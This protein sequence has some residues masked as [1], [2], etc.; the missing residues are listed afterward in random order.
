VTSRS[1]QEILLLHGPNLN[2]LGARDEVHYGQVT[3]AELVERV[4]GW[5]EEA[6]LGVRAVQ[7]NHEGELIDA[8]QD[9]AAWA[10]GAIVNA[11]ALTHT[12]YALHDALLDFGRPA[13]E[14]HLSRISEREPWRRVSV[15]RPACGA[16][17]EGEG[18]EGYR[19][20][21]SWLA[22]EI[23]ERDG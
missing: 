7:S 10:R 9:A 1:L 2:R 12:S 16:S 20:A 6:G 22:A 13:V 4:R 23:I 11:G 8:L 21:V 14:V 19:K 18:P 3:L 17:F 15:L 5:A